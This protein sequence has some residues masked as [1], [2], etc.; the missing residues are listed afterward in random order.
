MSI[1]SNSRILRL[2]SEYTNYYFYVL[3]GENH[4]FSE[5]LAEHNRNVA[6]AAEAAAQAGE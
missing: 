6:A 3:M 5:T 4:V 1:I 2:S